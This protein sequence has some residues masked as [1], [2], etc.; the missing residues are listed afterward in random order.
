MST[1]QQ[2]ENMKG[3]VK[4]ETQWLQGSHGKKELEQR[5]ME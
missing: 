5:E 4:R 1:W 2:L 3:K